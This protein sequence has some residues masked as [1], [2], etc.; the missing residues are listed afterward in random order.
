MQNFCTNCGA[1]LIMG[2]LFCT[3]CGS[4]I[5]GISAPVNQAQPQ[6]N[7]GQ[8]QSPQMQQI[9]QQSAQPVQRAQQPVQQG[10]P[11]QSQ[12]A[13]QVRQ[14]QQ[15]IQQQPAQRPMQQ[16]P[17][18][19]ARQTAPQP[20]QQQ[21]MQQHLQQGA[22][23]AARTAA[24]GIIS[25]AASNAM[26]LNAMSTPGHMG[27]GIITSVT[28]MSGT[29]AGT[30]Y[31]YANRARN[32]AKGGA[33]DAKKLIPSLIVGAV[34]VL[35][36]IVQ[37]IFMR[38]G[39]NPI[40]VKILNYLTFAR[41]GVSKNPLIFLGGNIGKGVVVAGLS[42]VAAGGI[43][44]IF[45]GAK[46]LFSQTNFSNENIGNFILGIGTGLLGYQICT[47]YGSLTGIMVAVS[48]ALITLRRTANAGR[49]A[50]IF[51]GATMGLAMSVPLAVIPFTFTHLIFGFIITFV[52]A[53]LVLAKKGNNN[54]AGNIR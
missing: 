9:Q 14:V 43:G 23:Q 19:P 45:A 30:V 17:V 24:S 5:E 54:A 18:Q 47:G 41:G 27:A 40:P 4:R 22:Q 46:Q 1:K 12:P 2:N 10:Q 29:V 33:I 8:P 20:V 48:G 28:G 26:E 6:A 53:I 31:G 39:I 36:W 11:V 16:Q 3:K 44:A 25:N 21:P 42:G 49:F 37:I 7:Q 38:K 35:L 15:P 13:Q 52:G 50:G 34:F 51:S 32:G